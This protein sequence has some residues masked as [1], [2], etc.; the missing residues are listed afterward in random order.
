[1]SILLALNKL[2]PSSANV[3]FL[4]RRFS[5]GVEEGHWLEVGLKSSGNFRSAFEDRRT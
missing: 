2:N 3:S 1:M 4:Y 5:G